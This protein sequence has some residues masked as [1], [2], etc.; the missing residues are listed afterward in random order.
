MTGVISLLIYSLHLLL[1]QSKELKRSTTLW[2]IET[3]ATIIES[4]N[5]DLLSA[6]AEAARLKKAQNRDSKNAVGRTRQII[7]K[8]LGNNELFTVGKCVLE[9]ALEIDFWRRYCLILRLDTI[10]KGIVTEI[11]K[12]KV[13]ISGSS[14]DGCW[15]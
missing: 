8:L 14:H 6:I 10:R 7:E 13:I 4:S 15:S 1:V 11:W 12:M 3:F 5:R 9:I 2:Y